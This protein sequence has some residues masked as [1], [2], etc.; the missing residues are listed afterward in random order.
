MEIYDEIKNKT[1]EMLKEEKKYNVH[2]VN[3]F[4]FT[5]LNTV[6]EIKISELKIESKYE[7]IMVISI[8]IYSKLPNALYELELYKI[9]N[10]RIRPSK[11]L[12]D[13]LVSLMKGNKE[14]MLFDEQAVVY[15]MCVKTMK[16]CMK[17]MKKRC[18]VVTGGPGTGVPVYS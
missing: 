8:M 10:G 1:L 11:A 2:A 9:D 18:I 17:D 13:C 6:K 12:Q 16:Q 7:F 5:F 15:D 14:F 3:D 4:V